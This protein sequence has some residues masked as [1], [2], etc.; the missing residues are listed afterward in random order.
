MAWW[1][2]DAPDA[3]PSLLAPVRQAGALLIC[4]ALIASLAVRYD[5][6][7]FFLESPRLAG[8]EMHPVRQAPGRAHAN[9]PRHKGGRRVTW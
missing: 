2:R 1:Y 8:V 4:S 9:L 5:P 6:V 3:G 7:D